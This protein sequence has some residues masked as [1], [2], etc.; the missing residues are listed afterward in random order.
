[1]YQDEKVFN[2][3][4]KNENRSA[5]FNKSRT[6]I[7]HTHTYIHT[8]LLLARLIQAYSLSSPH[9]PQLLFSYR[10]VRPHSFFDTFLSGVLNFSVRRYWR[11]NNTIILQTK[12]RYNTIGGFTLAHLKV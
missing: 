3:T 2:K 11:R 9:R 8:H 5:N 4:L 1:M 10:S 12:G 7:K 6:F